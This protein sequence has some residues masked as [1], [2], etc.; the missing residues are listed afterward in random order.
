MMLQPDSVA[1]T[2]DGALATGFAAADV[3]CVVRGLG[4]DLAAAATAFP[5]DTGAACTVDVTGSVTADMGCTASTVADADAV[6]LGGVPGAVA[7]ADGGFWTEELVP[8]FALSPAGA[9]APDDDEALLD[10]VAS[11]ELSSPAMGA[12]SS[13]GFPAFSFVPSTSMSLLQER[14]FSVACR[15]RTRRSQISSGMAKAALHAL[16]RTE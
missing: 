4:L 6:A 5:G 16:Q 3:A 12:G 14:H 10:G 9:D 13:D 2:S 1:A 8:A 11:R 15:P 7:R